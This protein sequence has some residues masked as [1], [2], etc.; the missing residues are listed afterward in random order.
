MLSPND[1]SRRVS[2]HLTPREIKSR[3]DH[4]V[5]DADGH[6][7]E[8]GPVFHEQ[9][10][11]VGGDIAVEGFS[12]VAGG[13]AD[14]LSMT[15]EE[16]R[17][18]RISQEAFWQHPEKNTRDRATAMFP[19]LL[20]ERLDELGLDFAVI[21]P[22]NGLRVPRVGDGERRRAACHAYNI[23][24]AEYFDKYRD[25]MTP[26]AI[27]G[28]LMDR[29]IEAADKADGEAAR[30]AVYADVIGL[31]SEFDYDAVWAKCLELGIAPSFHSGARRAGLRLSPSNFVY[32][33]IGHFAAAN[34]AACKA[35]F[36]G[37]VTRRFPGLN[38]SF[39]EAG[40]AGPAC[41][42]AICYRIGK[43]AAAPG[44]RTPTPATS[45]GRC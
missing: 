32:N 8:W 22:T 9:L 38:I 10:R 17:R 5:I 31:D 36:L 18:R 2:S 41:S 43:S 34:H 7:I 42:T 3:L 45:T 16:R 29:P 37:G 14:V 40:L 13:T 11:K 19:G 21:Y 39:L 1:R 20:Y 25:R 12:R 27:F 28:S 35:M 30:F 24:T 26:A 6:W 23:V 44:S 4:P 33:H 15:V